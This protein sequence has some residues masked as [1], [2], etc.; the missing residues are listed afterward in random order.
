MAKEIDFNEVN[1]NVYYDESSP[2]F[3]RW[4]ISKPGVKAGS[5]AGTLNQTGYYDV[6][7]NGEL[8][9]AHRLIW[10]LFN[11]EI[12]PDLDIDHKIISYPVNNDINNLRLVTHAVNMTN[13][14][15][16]KR[17]NKL[18]KYIYLD[19]VDPIAGEY[20]RAKIKNPITNKYVSKGNYD[21]SILLEWVKS[22]CKEFNIPY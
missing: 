15:D 5:V 4:K 19:K 1:E 14:S 18:P 21:L 13:K 7:I 9:K 22:K 11:K 20:Y 6:M 12:N 3:L 2:S 10:V 16:Y 8:Y 17:R